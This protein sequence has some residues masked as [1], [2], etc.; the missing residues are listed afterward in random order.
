MYKHARQTKSG[1]GKEGKR[2]NC[3]SFDGRIQ[4]YLRIWGKKEASVISDV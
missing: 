1:K 3:F 2:Q 4:N